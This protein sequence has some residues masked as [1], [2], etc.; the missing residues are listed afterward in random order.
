MNR[1]AGRNRGGRHWLLCRRHSRPRG[2]G[3]AVRKVGVREPKP[4]RHDNVA[5]C[6][7]RRHEAVGER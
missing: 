3:L 1:I 6:L 4:E 5:R 2:A 7:R